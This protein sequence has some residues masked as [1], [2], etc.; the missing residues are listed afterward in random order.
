MREGR[1]PVQ[2]GPDESNLA[3]QSTLGMAI[4]S[5]AVEMSPGEA[6]TVLSGSLDRARSASALSYLSQALPKA[7]VRM[8]ADGQEED[9]GRFIAALGIA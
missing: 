6:A 8:K 4:G 2:P 1:Y 9:F 3:G 5:L 7:V